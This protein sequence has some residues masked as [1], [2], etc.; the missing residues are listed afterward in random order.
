MTYQQTPNGLRCLIMNQEF[1]VGMTLRYPQAWVE[2][3]A[4]EPPHDSEGAYFPGVDV[5][6]YEEPGGQEWPEGPSN[7]LPSPMVRTPPR[8]VRAR[9]PVY[10]ED[11]L[12][13]GAEQA[14]GEEPI[15][16]E[17]ETSIV[18]ALVLTALGGL[19]V[20]WLISKTGKGT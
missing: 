11:L 15:A 6:A 1:H 20:W 14:A 3:H 10:S 18:P 8:V 2:K 13:A 16:D 7:G 12:Q 9:P 19:G 4:E 5:P 17:K